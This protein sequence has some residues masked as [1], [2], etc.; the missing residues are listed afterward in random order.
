MTAD[1]LTA[2]AMLVIETKSKNPRKQF[3]L[4]IHSRINKLRADGE[5]KNLLKGLK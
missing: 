1:L 2:Q 4:R 3:V 5:R